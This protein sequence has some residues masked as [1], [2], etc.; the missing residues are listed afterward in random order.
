MIAG[1]AAAETGLERGT[2]FT[3]LSRLT[4]AGQLQR[5]KRDYRLTASPSQHTLARHLGRRS[6]R[7]DR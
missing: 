6:Q 7:R 4:R 2:V 1:Q 3:N 5:A